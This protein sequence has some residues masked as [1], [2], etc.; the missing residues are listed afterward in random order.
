MNNLKTLIFV[1]AFCICCTT[2]VL[3]V[4]Y[5]LLYDQSCMDILEYRYQETREGDEFMA[6]AFDV[7]TS[8]RL[9]LQ[10]GKRSS[11]REISLADPLVVG[12]GD[13]QSV[14][15]PRLADKINTD[16][17]NVYIA[18][19]TDRKGRYL[20]SR[21]NHADYMGVIN[22][23]LIVRTRLYRLT[24]PI[25]SE[26]FLG[27]LSKTDPRGKVYF[28]SENPTGSCTSY[29]FIQRYDYN[30][31]SS[32]LIDV[33]PKVG[34]LSE[35]N[36]GT[37]N[38][39]FN[40]H[41]IN[42]QPLAN[43]L[44]NACNESVAIN[45]PGPSSYASGEFTARGV[46]Q[47]MPS[48]PPTTMHTVKKGETLYNLSQRYNVSVETIK[49]WNNLTSNLLRP[50]QQL[51]VRQ[52]QLKAYSNQQRTG[53]TVYNAPDLVTKGI[54]PSSVAAP[55]NRG[56]S[57]GPYTTNPYQQAWMTTDG[58]HIVS[59]Q[60]SVSTIA[61]MFGFTEERFRQFNGLDEFEQI[62]PGQIL[63]TV[64]CIEPKNR[65]T[66][67]TSGPRRYGNAPQQNSSLQPYYDPNA[68]FEPY[69]NYPEDFQ[70]KQQVNTNTMQSKGAQ[71]S[72]ST[73]GAN[74]NSQ[75]ESTPRSNNYNQNSELDY[76]GPVP[77]NYNKNQPLNDNN[78][79]TR[80]GAAPGPS[81]Y[82]VVPGTQN[83]SRYSDQSQ[84]L[85][86]RLLPAG[87]SNRNTY[88]VQAGETIRS[89]AQKLGMNEKK[90]REL[91]ELEKNEIVLE[92][93]KLYIN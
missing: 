75:Y 57:E 6:Y 40:L 83:T 23:Q 86:T 54:G 91:N 70:P 21:V 90:L 78:G 79:Y 46:T 36:R 68:N 41:R 56:G 45:Q 62:R 24:F 25:Q 9:I 72:P 73:Y 55:Y 18:T 64:D 43:Y 67:N 7:G 38:T 29:Q 11:Y 35:D 39:F 49:S 87:S 30:P 44:I 48:D 85:Y 74:L 59:Q 15:N 66:P 16:Q 42:G 52:Q 80:K 28:Q 27:D 81:S 69:A 12:C 77:G 93:Q 22:N 33:L 20:V 89:I 26:Q 61:R 50:D 88:T 10:T 5:Y 37:S 17:A 2:S 63:R 65:N 14:K 19:P 34:I 32:L 82:G 76:Y 84:K 47:Q 31:Q 13:R 4:D 92:S 3:A 53:P 71:P 8:E 1:S 58:Q 60:E 51:V